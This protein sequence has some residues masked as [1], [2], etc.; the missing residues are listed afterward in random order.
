MKNQICTT[1]TIGVTTNKFPDYAGLRNGTLGN[2]ELAIFL[3][4]INMTAF[5]KESYSSLS[6]DFLKH[7]F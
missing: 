1:F 2:K 3:L 7:I 4:E 6:D 5:L